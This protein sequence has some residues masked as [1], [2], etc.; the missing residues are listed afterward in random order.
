MKISYSKKNIIDTTIYDLIKQ[1]GGKGD[2]KVIHDI[3][4]TALKLVQDNASLTDKKIID[5]ALKEIR[6]AF[7][8]FAP[9]HNLNKVTVF[10]SARTLKKDLF[11]KKAEQFAKKI[12]ELGFM[13]ITGG[14][15]G[16]MEAAQK[17]AAREK[18]F[19]IN[20]DLPHEQKANK[21]IIDDSKCINFH[22]FFA[23]KLM[24]LKESAAIVLFP[25]GFGTH[26]EGFEALTL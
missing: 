20:I 11:Y 16:I 22:Y 6:Y 10:G 21:Y 2:E 9:Y 8:T 13:V 23:R 1:V 24:F 26:D 15:G 18:S 3:I 19:G 4:I 25:G 5:T 12:T 7:K 17:G 14:G